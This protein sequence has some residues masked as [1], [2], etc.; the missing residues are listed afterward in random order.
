VGPLV[1]VRIIEL[2]GLGPAPYCSMLLSDLGAEVIRIDRVAPIDRGEL[3]FDPSF[4]LLNRGRRSLAVDLKQPQ[5]VE[6]VL[7]LVETADA[8]VERF[9]PGVAERLG[10]GPKTCRARN[11]KLVY[12]RMTGWGQDGPLASAAASTSRRRSTLPVVVRGSSSMKFTTRGTLWRARRWTG[13]WYGDRHLIGHEYIVSTQIG[14]VHFSDR[15]SII[16]YR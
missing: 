8:L 10:L 5:G 4:D 3:N 9:R 7:R 2:A 16:H 14:A 1:G 11:R 15:F 13:T 6:L 12:G